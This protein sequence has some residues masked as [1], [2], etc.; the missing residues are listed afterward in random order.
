MN[1]EN[2]TFDQHCFGKTTPNVGI[3]RHHCHHPISPCPMLMRIHFLLPGSCAV[4]KVLDSRNSWQRYSTGNST[5]LS[6]LRSDILLKDGPMAV[7]A[8]I[9]KAVTPALEWVIE[10]NTH[11]WVDLV[12]NLVYFVWHIMCIMAWHRSLGILVDTCMEKRLIWDCWPNSYQRAIL[13]MKSTSS[14]ML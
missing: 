12:L 9:A 8:L 2:H 5:A 14:H 1:N 3:G 4:T 7:G 10:A 13:G 11:F 6:K